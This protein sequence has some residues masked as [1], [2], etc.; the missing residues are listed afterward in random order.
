[1]K[2]PV[3]KGCWSLDLGGGNWRESSAG[4]AGAVHGREGQRLWLVSYGICFLCVTGVC[5][6][7]IKMP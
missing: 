2:P 1:M 7:K 5:T 3:S 6:R 4:G